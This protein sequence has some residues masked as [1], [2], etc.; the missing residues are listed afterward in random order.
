[1]F[2]IHAFSPLEKVDIWCERLACRENRLEL[3]R[4]GRLHHDNFAAAL[5]PY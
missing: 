5:R 4:A 1:M 3:P 2:P